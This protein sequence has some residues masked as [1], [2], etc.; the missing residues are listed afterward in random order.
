MN[1][2]VLKIAAGVFLGIFAAFCVFRAYDY[3][4]TYERNKSNAERQKLEAEATQSR[5]QHAAERVRTLTTLETLRLCGRPI[6]E[7]DS[8]WTKLG[9]NEY[10]TTRSLH[11]LGEDGH[12]VILRFVNCSVDPATPC[13]FSEAHRQ[14][15]AH[16]PLFRD[17]LVKE[18]LCLQGD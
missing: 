4:E 1:H 11:Y 10:T 3:W 18:L 13:S 14:D 12:M 15:D 6:S 2:L 17:E 9:P 16:I 7:D 5:I 8:P